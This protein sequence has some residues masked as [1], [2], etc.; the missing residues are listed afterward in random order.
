MRFGSSACAFSA[1][2]AEAPKST[3]SVL[4][5]VSSQKQVLKRPPEPKASPEPT[6]VSFI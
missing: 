6:M 2:S 4:L 3:T 1:G 5:A